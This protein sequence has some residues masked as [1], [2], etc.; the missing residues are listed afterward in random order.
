M[1]PPCQRSSHCVALNTRK[2]F[3]ADRK[4][5]K[6]GRR[7]HPFSRNT[8]YTCSCIQRRVLYSPL[9]WAAGRQRSVF[10]TLWPSSQAINTPS[11]H[12]P[13]V[14]RFARSSQHSALYATQLFFHVFMSYEGKRKKKWRAKAKYHVGINYVV[15][16]KKKNLPYQWAFASIK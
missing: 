16:Q 15:P 6:W 13:F 7:R 2:K 1:K 10:L 5:K 11:R 8:F 9:Q 12:L 4:E 3:H 14:S